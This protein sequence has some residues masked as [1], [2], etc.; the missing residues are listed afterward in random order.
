[1]PRAET[2]AADAARE[3]TTRVEARFFYL[4]S[5]GRALSRLSTPFAGI[6]S[7]SGGST[8]DSMLLSGFVFILCK[9]VGSRV[10]MKLECFI[11]I[12]FL[13]IW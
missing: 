2:E 5:A 10:Y 6:T 11:I 12:R 3:A 8:S 4:G 13:K 7:E 1:M 9:S